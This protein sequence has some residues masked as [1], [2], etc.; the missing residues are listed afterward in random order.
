MRDLTSRREF[1][2]LLKL[3]TQILESMVEGVSVYDST[4]I[5]VYT[6]SAEDQ[7]FGYE[8][9]ELIG[10]H[11]TI[12]NTYSP[13]ENKKIVHKVIDQLKKKGYWSGEFNNKKKDGTKFATF[14]R[15]TSIEIGGQKHWVCVQ[16]DVS[17]RKQI[18]NQKD[19]FVGVATHEL[20]T[21]VTS[22]KAYTQILKNR[23]Q[24]KGDKASTDLLSKMDAQLDKLIT[25]IS[26]LLDVTKIEA[27]KMSF[28]LENFNFNA[29][30]GELI[31]E[32]QRTTTRHT[33]EIKGKA[34]KKVYG[35]RDRTGQV[36]TN[37]IS[38]AIKYS[39]YSDKINVMIS[40]D[41]K[42]VTLCVQDYGV[43]V[44]K[45]KQE[46]V[47]ERFYR[48]SGPKE[49]T[50]PGLGLGLY[51]S[52]EIVKRQGGRIWVESTKGKGST[53]CFS[54]PIKPR[55]IKQQKIQLLKVI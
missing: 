16:E 19:E 30:V 3:Q 5:I 21:P 33:I 4:G 35:D 38:N 10:K 29:L 22:I 23:F 12:Q 17:E 48:V 55:H 51:I 20:K 34:P 2:S 50:Y 47:F 24:K 1:R 42:G 28:N 9:R 25:L 15:I 44:P 45:K 6:N 27:G 36:L 53:F 52:S 26:D 18:E 43:G 37:L 41:S 39:P 46:R 40:Q 32:L 13:E 8:A 7:M 14:A 11:V 54:L 31:E 49:D